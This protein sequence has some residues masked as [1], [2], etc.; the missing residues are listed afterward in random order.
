MSA[1]MIAQLA[2]WLPGWSGAMNRS[3][4]PF[5]GGSLGAAG[6]TGATGATNGSDSPQSR[7]RE[8]V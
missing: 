8:I 1:Y 4:T 2:Q 5:C 6:A 3:L 7:R